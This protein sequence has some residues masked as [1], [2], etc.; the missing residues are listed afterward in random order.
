M[1]LNLKSGYPCLEDVKLN[2]THRTHFINI[3]DTTPENFMKEQPL[4][5]EYDL[6]NKYVISV[7]DRLCKPD[8]N[9][10]SSKYCFNIVSIYS[11]KQGHKARLTYNNSISFI[12]ITN[13]KNE[14]VSILAQSG[15]CYPVIFNDWYEA[16][17]S[18]YWD[19][20]IVKGEIPEK[21]E[22]IELIKL[23]IR[24]AYQN[25]DIQIDIKEEDIIILESL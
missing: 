12:T 8:K 17:I 23:L 16:K 9:N 11:P 25:P 14:I 1:N 20:E 15:E 18:D 4:E 6:T 7:E 3:Y 2:R 24:S 13:N 5:C 19:P 10:F 22:I 21:Y